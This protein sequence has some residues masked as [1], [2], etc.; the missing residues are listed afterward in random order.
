M[1]KFI[2][3]IPITID[4]HNINY[5]ID[6]HPG[7]STLRITRH[8][9]PQGLPGLLSVERGASLLCGVPAEYHPLTCSEHP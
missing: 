7:Q 2:T 8:R 1:K 5:L 9:N 6:G 4:D 3:T